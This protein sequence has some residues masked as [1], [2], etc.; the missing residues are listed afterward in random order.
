M[1]TYKS[2]SNRSLMIVLTIVLL[3][4]A[5]CTDDQSATVE[6]PM[7][8][9]DA[10]LAKGSAQARM[11]VGCH[12][13]KGISRVASYPSLAGK[14]GMYLTEQLEAFR[15]GTRVNPMMSSI[16]KS[17]SDD[18]VQALAYYFSE[19]TAPAAPDAQP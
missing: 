8:D 19:Q 13:P 2:L 14:P 10:L 7:S 6:T 12:G 17:L 9:T 15:E 16:A 3:G 11:C 18:D 4:V 5:G 1:Q